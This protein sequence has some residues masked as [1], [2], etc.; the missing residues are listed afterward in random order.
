MAQR[1]ATVRVPSDVV[2]GPGSY[3]MLR[4]LGYAQ[5]QRATKM[6]LTAFGGQMPAKLD[7]A[8]MTPTT[9]LLDGN[10]EF[11]RELLTEN[12]VAWNWVDDD[13]KELALPREEGVIGQLTDEEVTFLVTAIRGGVTAEAEKN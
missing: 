10:D 3:V 13:G 1:M 11:T 4:K 8:E 7:M 2:Q 12:V 5:R 6:L 9:E